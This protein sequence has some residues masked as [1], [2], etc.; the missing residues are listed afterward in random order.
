MKNKL[1]ETK[2]SKV[3]IGTGA[4]VNLD[5]LN[6]LKQSLINLDPNQQINEVLSSM[7]IL[8]PFLKVNP[9]R[10][11][12]ESRRG[13]TANIVIPN[14]KKYF[15]NLKILS[16]FSLTVTFGM[17]IIYKGSCAS[18]KRQ[19]HPQMNLPTKI[20]INVKKPIT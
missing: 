16:I 9:K 14:K 2:K 19:S 15:A 12:A 13:S 5:Q 7:K 3:K 8:E 4:S 17:G 20:P 11:S 6:K 18:P 1:Y 10:L